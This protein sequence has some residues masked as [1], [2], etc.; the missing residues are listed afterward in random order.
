MKL[1]AVAIVL[2]IF[3]FNGNSFAQSKLNPGQGFYL[4][5]NPYFNATQSGGYVLLGYRFN[6]KLS[7]DFSAFGTG[8]MRL[9]VHYTDYFRPEVKWGYE[10]S[11]SYLLKQR[12][13]Y[14]RQDFLNQRGFEA[15]IGIFRRMDVSPNIQF[16]PTLTYY[17]GS[18][19]NQFNQHLQLSMPIS[20]KVFKN[21]T[22]SLIPAIQIGEDPF[23]QQFRRGTGFA[24]RLSLGIR[25]N[26]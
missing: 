11:G 15:R 18:L 20:F 22:I 8:P 19:G 10:L 17:Q 14:I 23:F 1:K 7:T 2:C 12:G 9:Q 6:H 13:P 4:G 5:S 3:V 25:I 16:L 24:S 26:F 21:S